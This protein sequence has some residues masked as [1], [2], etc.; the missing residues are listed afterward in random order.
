M[1]RR[2][3]PGVFIIAAI[4]SVL[5]FSD[6]DRREGAGGVKHKQNVYFIQLNNV[7]DVEE[8]ERGVRDAIRDAG[9]LEHRDFEVTVLNAQGDM[10]SLGSL[11]DA[12]VSGG[13]DMLMTWSTPTLQAAVRRSA[14][15]PVVFTYVANA[16]VAG[17]GKS[18]TDHLPNITGV[19]TSFDFDNIV[20]VTKMVFPNLRSIGTLF[21]PA[22][23]NMV[24][25]KDQLDAAC[26]RAGVKLEAMG[27]ATSSEVGEAA[28]AL[29]ARHVD[30]ICQIP[31]N[32]TASSFPSIVHAADQV[33][34]PIIGT[35]KVHGDQGAAVVAASDWRQLGEES[36]K[37]AA[38]VMRGESPAHIPFGALRVQKLYVN[39]E[40][41]K[42]NGVTIPAELL[43]Q[44]TIIHGKEAA[45]GNR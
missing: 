14:G 3:A 25:F 6:I 5:L 23:V 43:S 38:R 11:I 18:A 19:N 34:V 29:C 22:E 8:A 39:P 35:Q 45:H 12:A 27:A 44:S 7:S 4:S 41:A 40:A 15:K 26:K 10:A 36:G 21:V 33:H 28:S 42:K 16:V 24:Y 9:L 32:L 31:G 13:A 2:L 30:A 1:V 37:L 20:R 17:A